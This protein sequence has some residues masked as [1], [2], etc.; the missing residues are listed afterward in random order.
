MDLLT[1]IGFQAGHV[2]D[3]IALAPG[4]TEVVFAVIAAR[5]AGGV[6]RDV[7]IESQVEG[8]LPKG[9]L[10]PEVGLTRVDGPIA[11]LLQQHGQGL[12]MD[13]ALNA[14]LG[15]QAVYI[16]GRGLHLG[17]L[18][19]RGMIFFQRPVRDLVPGSVH[20]GHEADA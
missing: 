14:G 15:A 18:P 8:I 3:A 11:C 10:G 20:A 9:P 2:P 5:P 16:P 6:T 4:R 13:R 19:V 1:V 12:G 17:V 7:D